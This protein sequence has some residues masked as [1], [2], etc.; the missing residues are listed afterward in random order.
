MPRDPVTG[1]FNRVDNSFSDPVLGTEIDPTDAS[2]LFDDYDEA[3][4][5]SI[6]TEPTVVTVDGTVA[7]D[8]AT[9]AIEK[10]APTATALSLPTVAAR[11]GLPLHIVDW[12]T[13]VTDHAITLT[14]NAANTGGIMKS[15]TLVLNSTSAQL[16]SVTLYPSE[17]LN[18]W[19]L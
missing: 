1:I 15:A 18:G 9:I 16:A 14:P 3:L 19:Y 7:A 5:A 12:S 10:T 6:P 17:T 4:T 13:S 11:N 8:A 2:A